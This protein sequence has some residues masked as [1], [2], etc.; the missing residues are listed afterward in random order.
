[1]STHPVSNR[2][3]DMLLAGSAHLD[4]ILITEKLAARP[5]RLPRFAKEN[6][7]LR[8]LAKTMAN[9]PE[10]LPDMLLQFAVELCNA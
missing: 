4:E 9:A 5:P 8:T 10:Q 2:S 7:A 6:E 1:M 3:S